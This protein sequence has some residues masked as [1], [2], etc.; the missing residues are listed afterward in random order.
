M[1]DMGNHVMPVTPVPHDDIL[2][3]VAALMDERGLDVDDVAEAIGLGVDDFAAWLTGDRDISPSYLVPLA[4]LLDVSVVA[5]LEPDSRVAGD[6]VPDDGFV[7]GTRPFVRLRQ[8]A[9]MVEETI[10]DPKL[11]E[12]CRDHRMVSFDNPASAFTRAVNEYNEVVAGAIGVDD[13]SAGARG[14]V[15]LSDDE[16][17][18]LV[19]TV[20]NISSEMYDDDLRLTA[21]L[22]AMYG[23][24]LCSAPVEFALSLID[25]QAMLVCVHDNIDA[26]AAPADG[27][28]R[29]M[30]EANGWGDD[31]DDAGADDTIDVTDTDG[32][33]G[34]EAV[35]ECNANPATCM[36]G[37][38]IAKDVA[39]DMADAVDADVI[40]A[41]DDDDF[42]VEDLTG[43]RDDEPGEPVEGQM[44]FAN[45]LFG[46]D[47]E[48]L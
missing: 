9:R 2:E 44:S 1:S 29:R 8:Y 38:P 45:D 23:R 14:I 28:W 17:E 10:S 24:V 12:L 30:L 7:L 26:F 46:D 25:A 6:D 32:D 27:D 11:L 19:G 48:P 21:D 3:N 40:F 41:D 37:Q 22:V 18:A 4:E 35:P 39:V 36:F 43:N 20:E 33:A 16:Y 13:M 31:D 5:L 47:G 34:T 42:I 15:D